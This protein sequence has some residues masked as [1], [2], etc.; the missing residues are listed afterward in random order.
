MNQLPLSEVG[1]NRFVLSGLMILTVLLEMV[2][3]VAC[4]DI[5]WPAVPSK[6]IIAMRLAVVTLSGFISPIAMRPVKSTLAAVNG[7]GGTKKSPELTAVPP[8]VVTV[9]CPEVA[10]AGTVVL[11]VVA[12]ADPATAL[13]MLNLI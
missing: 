13:V 2:L 8:A 9:M 6:T 5:R 3:L 4:R 11:M 7:E 10:F 1:L 12:V